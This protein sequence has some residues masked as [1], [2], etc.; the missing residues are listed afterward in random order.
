V[1]G[2]WG[3][4]GGGMVKKRMRERMRSEAKTNMCMLPIRKWVSF[5]K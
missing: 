1:V 3:A 2:G 5:V 4:G